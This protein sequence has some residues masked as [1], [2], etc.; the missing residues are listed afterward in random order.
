VPSYISEGLHDLI[1]HRRGG[2][3]FDVIG[4]REKNAPPVEGS[5]L[6]LV[7][8]CSQYVEVD[9]RGTLALAKYPSI[10]IWTLVGGRSGPSPK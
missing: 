9:S 8:P 2:G 6:F 4:D 1:N 5:K 3:Y 10:D 7:D